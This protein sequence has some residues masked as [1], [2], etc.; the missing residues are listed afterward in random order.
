MPFS[1]SSFEFI[2]KF[3][4]TIS[5]TKDGE[6]MK[7]HIVSSEP[8]HNKLRQ[9]SHVFNDPIASY[10]DGFCNQSSPPLARGEPQNRGDEDL[11]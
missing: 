7:D 3:F 6:P 11:I 4:K 5:E 2:K 9:S 10:L 1:F 8:I